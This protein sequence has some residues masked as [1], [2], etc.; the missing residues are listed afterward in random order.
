[1]SFFLLMLAYGIVTI[2][3]ETTFLYGLPTPSVH[4]DFV[5]AAVAALAFYQ[6]WK[7]ALPVVIMLG[8]LMDISSAA[9]FGLTVLSYLIIYGVI[10]AIIAKISF[11]S[12]AALLFWVAMISL[13]NK[14]VTLV[15]LLAT[16]G[17]AAY[18]E[19]IA[20]NAPLQALL[21]AAL[22]FAMIPFITWYW[23]LSWEK[24]T[25]PKGLV[26]K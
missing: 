16:T 3:F 17:D 25:R 8:V 5:I 7:R 12:G 22:A 11:Q 2:V 20:R 26:L 1:M 14:F 15:A 19:I 13:I 4:F 23:D 21:D 6:E 9:P 10:R 18:I 24:I